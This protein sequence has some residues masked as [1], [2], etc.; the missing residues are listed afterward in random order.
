[1]NWLNTVALLLAAYLAVFFESY[2]QGFRNVFG[3]QIDLLPALVVYASL[4]TNI[5]TVALLATL[6]GFWFDSLSANP[7][8]ITVLPLFVVGLAIHYWRDLILREQAYAQFVLGLSASAFVPICTVVSLL[9]TGA[10]P[11]L[12]WSSVWRW[13]VMTA[14]GAAL[15][16][17]VFSVLDRLNRAFNY[18][19]MPETSFRPD[20]EIKRG[21][22]PHMDH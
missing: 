15:T 6:G 18:Q 16:P 22:Q 12:G 21:R 4:T 17:A 9:G 8:G 7:L 2:Y 13:I 10:E 3:A 5:A 11:L 14:G 20:R 19:P 1:M